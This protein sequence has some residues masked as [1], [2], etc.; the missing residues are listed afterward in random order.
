ML[1][2]SPAL[3]KEIPTPAGKQ[4]MPR[5][6]LGHV[7]APAWPWGSPRDV[8]S[9][10]EGQRVQGW[11]LLVPQE[12]DS[13]LPV[14]LWSSREAKKDGEAEPT[15]TRPALRPGARA[16]AEAAEQTGQITEAPFALQQPFFSRPHRYVLVSH[17]LLA[18]S[19]V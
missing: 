1:A 9:C 8:R 18:P 15:S 19:W 3:P 10:W 17:P 11:S 5:L 7:L 6:H 14:L 2:A 16:A 13:R 12:G 4:K